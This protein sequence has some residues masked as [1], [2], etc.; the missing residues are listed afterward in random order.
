MGFLTDQSW[1]VL[2]SWYTGGDPEQGFPHCF[3]DGLYQSLVSSVEQATRRARGEKIPS[4]QKHAS[5]GNLTAAEKKKRQ[6][7][8]GSFHTKAFCLEI[9]FAKKVGGYMNGFNSIFYLVNLY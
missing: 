3:A 6:K 9:E 8:T 5:Y 1:R 4:T 2:K 7:L